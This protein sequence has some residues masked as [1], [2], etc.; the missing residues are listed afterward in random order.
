M[1]RRGLLGLAGRLVGVR[2]GETFGLIGENGSGKSTMLK[3]LTKILRPDKGAVRVEGK[4]SALLEL[5]R[6][7]IRS[8][9]AVRTCS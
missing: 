8:S 5:E 1:S 3:C 6:G 7:F 2:E 9:L 4:V